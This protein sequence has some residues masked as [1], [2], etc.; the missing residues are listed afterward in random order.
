MFRVVETYDGC[1]VRDLT[2]DIPTVATAKQVLKL[3]IKDFRKQLKA[4]TKL[5]LEIIDKSTDRYISYVL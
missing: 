5:T 3:L 2:I 4:D 1:Y